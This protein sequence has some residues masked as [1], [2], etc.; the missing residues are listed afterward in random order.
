MP[1]LKHTKPRHQL[2]GV[3]PLPIQSTAPTWSRLAAILASGLIL[4]SCGGAPEQAAEGPTGTWAGRS[5]G[6]PPTPKPGIRN[7]LISRANAEWEYFGRQTVVLRGT[8]ESI[9]HV[10]SW[11]DDGRTYSDRVNSYWRAA[12]KPG[13]DGMDCRQPWS[14]AF[15]SWIMQSAGVPESQF[16]PAS[17]HW[18][19]LADIIDQAPYP[20]RWF[21]PRRIQDYSPEPGDLICASRGL[22]RPAT[23]NGYTSPSMLAGYNTHCDLV[24]ATSGQTLDPIGANVT[25]SVSRTSIELDGEGHLKPVPRRPW[26]VI[27]QSRL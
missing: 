11:E 19:Y 17:A 16:R 13:L 14:A 1:V 27:I 10:G 26:F 5:I 3:H 21:I 23:F 2:E 18:V 20:G 9:P 22:T 8:E 4:A 24:V 12:G 15:I 25:N 6:A 7:A